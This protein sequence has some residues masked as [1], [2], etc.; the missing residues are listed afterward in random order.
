MGGK[1]DGCINL[2]NAANNGLSDVITALE[3]V[4]LS[5]DNAI[6]DIMSRADYWQLA[7]TL[8]IKVGIINANGDCETDE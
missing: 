8:S 7:A 3:E 2:D 6:Y 5:E 4:Y 1:C